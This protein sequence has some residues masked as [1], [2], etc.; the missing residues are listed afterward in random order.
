MSSY[1]SAVQIYELSFIDSLI[2]FPVVY[3][4]SFD[5]P[6]RTNL[7]VFHFEILKK[8]YSHHLL[9]ANLQNLLKIL[10]LKFGTEATFIYS[11]K[12]R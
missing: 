8:Q 2:K 1:F 10:Y 3:N 9:F 5:L 7:S 12:L 6:Y 4:S 11:A